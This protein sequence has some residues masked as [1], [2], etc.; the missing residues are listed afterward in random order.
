MPGG[1]YLVE[2]GDGVARA[3]LARVLPV[4]VEVAFGEQT[5]LV[6]DESVA[7]DRARVELDLYLHVLRYGR[8]RAGDLFA[9]S[10]ARL[11]LGVNVCVVAVP[12]VGQLL[13][14]RVVE[15]ARAD[16]EHREEDSALALLLDESDERLVARHADVEVA[17]GREYDAVR[18]AGTEVLLRDAVC[19][20]DSLAAVRRA[21]GFESVNRGDYLAPAVAGRRRQ[22]ESARPR[23]CD[24]CD[25]VARVQLLGERAQRRLDE[26]QFV[27]LIHRAG[28]VNEED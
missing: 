10:L 27:R 26:R 7:R 18:A 5:V 22:D 15:V 13:H 1:D 19:E 24:D 17:V 21:S 3:Y 2:R 11:L 6:A 9:E 23:V 20:L 12:L 8:E 28:N 4:V 25:A 14:H 16:A